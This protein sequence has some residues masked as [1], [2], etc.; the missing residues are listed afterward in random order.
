MSINISLYVTIVTFGS[1]GWVFRKAQISKLQAAK[2]KYLKRI[3]DITKRDR[4]TN[5]F[6]QNAKPARDRIEK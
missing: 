4:V 5:D 2:V 6:R 1:E 3:K